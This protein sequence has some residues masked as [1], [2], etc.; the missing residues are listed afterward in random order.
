MAK[1]LTPVDIGK[2]HLNER[3][4]HRGKRI[5]N[6]NA[7]VGIS[8]GVN[9]DAGTIIHGRLYGIDQLSLGV[10][11]EKRDSAAELCSQLPDGTV[12]LLHGQ[13]TVHFRL[14]GS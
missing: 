8:S 14:A 3:Q 5:A 2:M 4:L 13:R 12:D 9:K 6:S 7:C 10:G 1:F 11:L